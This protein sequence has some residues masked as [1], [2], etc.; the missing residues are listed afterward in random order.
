MDLEFVEE[1]RKINEIEPGTIILAGGG[2]C[3]DERLNII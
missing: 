3:I 2:I 1:L